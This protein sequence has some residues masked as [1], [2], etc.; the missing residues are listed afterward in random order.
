VYVVLNYQQIG[1]K[2]ANFLEELL[3]GVEGRWKKKSHFSGKVFNS[4]V[5]EYPN[6]NPNGNPPF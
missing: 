3:I 6:S 4:Y 5:S 2:N 1:Q